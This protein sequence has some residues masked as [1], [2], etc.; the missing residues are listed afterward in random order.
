MEPIEALNRPIKESHK[1]ILAMYADGSYLYILLQHTENR[2][3]IVTERLPLT[4]EK[5]VPSIEEAVFSQPILTRPFE[6]VFFITDSPRFIFIPDAFASTEDNPLYFDFCFPDSE[7]TFLTSLMSLVLPAI[8]SLLSSFVKRTLDRPVLLHRLAPACEYFFRKNRLGYTSKMYVHWETDHID[9]FCFNQQGFLLSNSFR[10]RHINDGIYYLLNAWKQLGFHA[11][12]DELSLSGNHEN[13]R[14]NVIP[15]LRKHLSYITLTKFPS[16]A[17]T[18][19]ENL[20][21]PLR[22]ISVYIR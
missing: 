13:L 8:I 22:L 21:L 10:I 3:E 9:L 18:G 19:K 20:P 2:D 6:K 16:H 15:A 1:Y 17:L 11:G 12:E 5:G 14:Q 4:S 7:G